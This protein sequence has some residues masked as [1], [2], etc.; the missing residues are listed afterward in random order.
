MPLAGR[1][2]VLG[3]TGG[4]AAYKAADLCRRL[5]D[6]GARVT[7]VLSAGASQF[8]GPIT[9]TALAGEP[10]RL[11]LWEDSAPIAHIG[12][13]QQADLVVVAPATANLLARYACGLADDLLTSVLVA[14]RA[15]VVLCPAMHTEMWEHPAT[16]ANLDTLRRR[17]VMVVRPESGR[18]AGGDIGVGRLAQAE[19]ILDAAEQALAQAE[20]IL[21][22]AEQVPTEQVPTE[23]VPTERMLADRA[24]A[25]ARPTSGDLA[26]VSV[27]V[28]AGGTREPIDPVRFIANRSSGR[29]GHALADEAVAR[30]ARVTLVTTASL[31]APPGAEVLRVETA[32]E[33][34][35][36]VLEYGPAS[37]AV[38]MAAA[39]ADF[40]PVSPAGDKLHRSDGPLILALQPTADILAVLAE[41]RR[42]GQV[43]VGF[44]AETGDLVARARAKLAQKGLDLIV[45]NDVSTPGAGFD[46]TTNAVVVLG[47]DGSV[48][49]VPLTD[50]HEVA[51]VVLDAV[52][53]RLDRPAGPARSASTGPTETSPQN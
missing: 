17:G 22:L 30:G 15:P 46:H 38:V 25:T 3:V 43:L 31:P 16:Q 19:S 47:A 21:A 5:V 27:L 35:A 2:V 26:G 48:Q 10:A 8:V 50:K 23:Q 11:S 20:A 37:Q 1:R 40:R 52:V 28:T 29:Q 7:P 53:A 34:Q 49:N 32:E 42:P 13:A 4:I 9:F 41:R 33:M 51:S 45:A 14:T 18:L 44:A 12:L 6:A 36:A 24:P 39:P